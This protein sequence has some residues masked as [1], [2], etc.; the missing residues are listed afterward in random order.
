MTSIASSLINTA[1]IKSD[2]Q[3]D[4]Q[5]DVKSDVKVKEVKG[6]DDESDAVEDNYTLI[7]IDNKTF[8][9]PAK[10]LKISKL[11]DTLINEDKTTK[12]FKVNVEADVLEWIK[13]YINQCKGTDSPV[14]PKPLKH[15]DLTKVTN[16]TDAK[17]ANTLFN[18]DKSLFYKTLIAGNYLMIDGLISLLCAKVGSELRGTPV[19]EIPNKL[20]DLGI[21]I[22]DDADKKEN[23]EGNFEGNSNTEKA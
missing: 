5:L 21:K 4:V 19:E 18:K 15:K 1:D 22:G 7:S 6:L 12:E 17:F 23:S 20:K 14:I 8:T 2:V 11:I 13:E 16:E 3:L 9:L 10:W